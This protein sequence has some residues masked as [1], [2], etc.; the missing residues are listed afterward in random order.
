MK[1]IKRFEDI[2][3]QKRKIYRNYKYGD[4]VII[5]YNNDT[6]K[7]QYKLGRKYVIYSLTNRQQVYHLPAG[8]IRRATPEEIEEYNIKKDSNKYNL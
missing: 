5:M 4:I 6:T 2:D 3:T 7:V 8:E 1:Y